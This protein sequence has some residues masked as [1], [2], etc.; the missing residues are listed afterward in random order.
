MVK[1][2][3]H[4]SIGMLQKLNAVSPDSELVGSL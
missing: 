1:G 3:L 4:D 2:F